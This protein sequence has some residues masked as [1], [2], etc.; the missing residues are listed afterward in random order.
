MEMKKAL[1]TISALLLVSCLP[2]T[3]TI[4]GI[5]KAK[6]DLS[7]KSIKHQSGRGSEVPISA[8]EYDSSITMENKQTLL[9][10]ITKRGQSKST[11]VRFT[12]PKSTSLPTYR[13]ELKLTAKEANQNYDLFAQVDTEYDTLSTPVYETESCTSESHRR[14]C[15]EVCHVENG[16]Q[17]CRDN[18]VDETITHYG[19]RE[20]EYHKD[21]TTQ[22][23][24]IDI[25]IPGT[26]EV[27]GTFSGKDIN[28]NKVYDYQ[29]RCY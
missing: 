28:S 15:R 3:I 12:I 18:C 17:I 22:N 5:F 6:E 8:G 24:N 20:V 21:Y 7:F 2:E 14:V 26:E 13:G 9:L 16:R 27:V 25:L 19:T 23:F 1:L 4:F 10:T 29:G 11:K